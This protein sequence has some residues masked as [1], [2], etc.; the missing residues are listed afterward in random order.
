MGETVDEG[1]NTEFEDSPANVA[2]TLAA[3]FVATTL[4]VVSL[5]GVQA[6][7]GSD[8]RLFVTIADFAGATESAPLGVALFCIG[9]TIVW[10]LIFASLGRYLPGETRT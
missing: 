6:L 7:Y 8:F 4:M 10:P 3:G 9:G 5:L 1:G 2:K